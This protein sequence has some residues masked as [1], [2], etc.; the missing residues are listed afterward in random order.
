MYSVQR[1]TSLPYLLENW[2][3]GS[4]QSCGENQLWC[5]ASWGEVNTHSAARH[6]HALPF[7]V[8]P[9]FLAFPFGIVVESHRLASMHSYA[10]M[11]FCESQEL[12]RKWIWF[13]EDHMKLFSDFRGR[14]NFA[15]CFVFKQTQNLKS[16]H[17]QTCWVPP[18]SCQI[19]IIPQVLHGLGKTHKSNQNDMKG[20]TFVNL[21]DKLEVHCKLL[22]NLKPSGFCLASFEV[23]EFEKSHRLASFYHFII[24]KLALNDIFFKA[25][26]LEMKWP[27][28][29]LIF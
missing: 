14:W 18:G 20:W 28:E 7:I 29:N 3:S 10:T 2:A 26:I 24:M 6:I 15:F 25:S 27:C 17:C 8:L 19:P 5:S 12:C 11:D 13:T 23:H 16:R 22:W 4:S 21:S 9:G 1:C